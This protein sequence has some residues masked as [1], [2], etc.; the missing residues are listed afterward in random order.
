[1]SL[2]F[3]NFLYFSVWKKLVELGKTTWEKHGNNHRLG[4]TWEKPGKNSFIDDKNPKLTAF[5]TYLAT[6]NIAQREGVR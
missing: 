3:C 2:D 6:N 1:M 4:K 5:Y